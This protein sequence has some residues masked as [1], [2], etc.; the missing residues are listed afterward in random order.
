MRLKQS[1]II[2]FLISFLLVF[3]VVLS[4]LLHFL[5]YSWWRLSVGE[6]IWPAFVITTQFSLMVIIP[7]H[8]LSVHKQESIEELPYDKNSRI[9][10]VFGILSLITSPYLQM[11][12][13][14]I[15]LGVPNISMFYIGGILTPIMASVSIYYGRKAPKHFTS[16]VGITLSIISLIFTIIILSLQLYFLLTFQP[17]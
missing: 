14:G 15:L 8:M 13:S 5:E 2:G 3:I 1:I 17:Y 6:Y 7:L 16:H 10:L 9:S 4:S 12:I 11:I